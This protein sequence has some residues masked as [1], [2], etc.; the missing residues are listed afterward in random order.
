MIKTKAELN[1]GKEYLMRD[2][3]K[4]D[5][6]CSIFYNGLLDIEMQCTKILFHADLEK[7]G[8]QEWVTDISN[9]MGTGTITTRSYPYFPYLIRQFLASTELRYTTNK[10]GIQ[11]ASEGT[12]SYLAHGIYHEISIPHMCELYGF[13]HTPKSICFPYD[14]VWGL[15]V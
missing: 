10:T 6:N 2:R 1:I 15:I 7:L 13:D 11:L 14:F 9:S 4:W 8:M 3:K 5:D 12:L